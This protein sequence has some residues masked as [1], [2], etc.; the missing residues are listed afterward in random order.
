VSR[1]QR[2]ARLGFGLFALIFAA[3]LWF[4]IDERRPPAPSRGVDRL[5]P[6]AVSEI[7]GGDVVQVKGETRDIRVEFA[8]QVLYSDGS[9]KYT[10]F[11]AFIDDRG[12]RSFEITG[13]EA[14][15]AAKQ[16]AFDV[17]GSVGLRTSDGLVARTEQAIFAEA[18]GI[19]RGPGPIS[20]ERERVTGSGVGFKYERSIDRL[21]LLDRAV[22]NVAPAANGGG[23]AVRSGSAAHS[24][25][26][27]FLRFERGMHMEREG[28]VIV[29]DTATVFLLQDR[30]EP[31][32][33]ELRGNASIAG[34]GTMG[35]LQDMQARDMNLRYAPDGRT[36]QHVLLVG[37]SRLQL[38][39]ADGSA[40]QQLFAETTDVVLAG[41]GSITNLAG[42][43]NVKVTIPAVEGASAREV[44]AQTVTGTGAAGGGLRTMLF[45]NAVT[46]REDVPGSNPRVVRSR[47]LNAGVSEAGAIETAHFSGGF[48]FEDG[49]MTARSAEAAY[50]TTK[51]TLALRSPDAA[52]PPHI[53]DDRVDLNAVSID[54]TLSPRRLDAT[55]K[56]RALFAAGRRE[57]ERGAT[58]LNEDEAILVLCDKLTFD[59]TSGAGVYSGSA[60]MLQD[61]GNTIRADTIE[62]NE[63]TGQLLATGSVITSL[64]LA[65]TKEEGAKGNSTGRAGQF[66]FDD[67]T[68]RAVYT[69]QA[70]LES[71][72]GNLRAERIELALVDQGNDLQQMTAD[73]GVKILLDDREAS[74]QKLVYHPADERYVLDGNPVSLVQGCQET[75]GRT[76]TFYRGSAN[77]KV[78]GQDRIRV[79]TK[80]GKCPEPPPHQ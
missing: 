55:E 30:D 36:L 48:V 24:R 78:D 66:A 37:Q 28:Q 19:L 8:T 41:D 9:A 76:L 14:Q 68:R 44:T 63:K 34:N 33:V 51:G 20:F 21:E 52:D 53:K 77:V 43:D 23:M 62:M 57:G 38:A 31:E 29:A 16:S 3:I 74:G 56:V 54:V 5:D 58:L 7:K 50:D 10:G 22:I 2:Q 25:A 69:K 42:R 47:R 17:R 70:Q 1:W 80:G 26:E 73:G 32:V 72:Q 71:A 60:R 59:E 35:S 15:V 61:S 65:S 39:R 67:A 49:R 40:G 79:T 4:V 12:G 46:Y 27:R 11:K 64:P 75:A 13:N 6:Q 18:D 45:E